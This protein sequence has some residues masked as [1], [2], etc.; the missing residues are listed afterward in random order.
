VKVRHAVFDVMKILMTADPIGGVWNYALELCC[1]L[2]P[3]RV[4]VALATLGGK[5]SPAQRAQ[6]AK[7][8]NVT[9]HASAF[10]LEW[11]PEPWGDLDRAG[12]W[13]LALEREIEPDV[14]HLNHLVHADLRWKTPVLTVGHSCVLSWWAAVYGE[15]VPVQWAVYRRRVTS[16]LQAARC[17]VAPSQ[18]M[19]IELERYY[20]PFRQTAVIYNARSRRHFSAGHKEPVVLS[21]G[22]I[23]DHAKNIAALAAAAPRVAAP[24]LVA[25][26]TIEE[27][28]LL[29][30]LLF[31]DRVGLA[32]GCRSPEFPHRP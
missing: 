29:A 32:L 31:D 7:L 3:Q 23:W 22:R 12:R 2:A 15:P 18:A 10:R 20:G 24:I 27:C 5:P 13:L 11:M 21:A 17:V 4:H 26:E 25:G 14:V 8:P 6:L 16:S 19:L 9:L 1:A 28:L 30:R